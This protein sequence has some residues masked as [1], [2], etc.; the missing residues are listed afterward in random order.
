MGI[1]NGLTINAS[2][3]ALERL[4]LDTIS[5]NIAN[6]NTNQ[7]TDTEAYQK[8]SV[9]FSENLKNSQNGLSSESAGVKVTG[10]DIDDSVKLAYDPTNEAADENGYVAQ[11]NVD[12]ADEMVQMIQTVRTYEANVSASEMNKTILKKA[13]EI[14]KG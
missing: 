9:Q 8:K 14:S 12:I 5:A 1:F 3:L 10:I 13:L 11:S 2:G 7:T 6:V 4:K